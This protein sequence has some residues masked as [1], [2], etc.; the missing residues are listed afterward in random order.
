[1]PQQKGNAEYYVV[2]SSSEQRSA[3][4]SQCSI[5]RIEWYLICIIVI[6]DVFVFVVGSEN[7]TCN[8][9]FCHGIN[10]LTK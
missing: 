8:R 4:L 2:S 3:V 10:S 6:C 1:M 7:V 9:K 5:N